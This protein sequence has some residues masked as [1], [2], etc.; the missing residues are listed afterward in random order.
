METVNYSIAL[1]RFG[2]NLMKIIY[3]VKPLAILYILLLIL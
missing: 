3:V 1:K 2:I